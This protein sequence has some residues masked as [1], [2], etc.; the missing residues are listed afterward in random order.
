MASPRKL[1]P[2]TDP[3]KLTL[4]IFGVIAFMY[5]AGEVLKPLILSVLL[6]FGLAPAA[7]Y[8]ER[9]GLPRAAAVVLTGVLTLGTLGS[10]GYV[11]GQQLTA[12]ANRLPD[13]QDNI[14]KKLN[15]VIQPGQQS[16]AERL[17]GFA[18]RLSAK[19]QNP[20]QS[21]QD[22]Q[23]PVQK[24]EVISQPSFQERL[25]ATIGPYLEFLGLGSFVLVLV[26]F[27]LMG[28]DDLGDRIIQLFGHQQVSLT[29][30]TTEEIGRRITRY[31]A[32]FALVN[33]S[34]GLVIG[35]GLALI[36]VPYSVLWGCLAAM[37]RFIPYVGPAMA[38]V[39]PLVFSFAQFPGWAQPLEVI[40][41]FA[42][43]ELVMNS[44][45]EPVIYGKTTGVSALGLLVAAMFWT[46][47]W[48]T[49]GLLLSTPMTVCLAVLGKYVPN[50]RFFATLLGED[51]ELEPDVRFY[52]RLVALDRGG[53]VAL[54][55]E[56]LKQKPRVEVFDEV[57]IPALSRAERDAARDELGE[58]EQAFVWRVVDEII[59]N[60]EGTTE[61]SLAAPHFG[62]DGSSSASGNAM[63]SPPVTLLGIAV[64]DTSD[65]LVLKML[66]QLIGPSGC[67][68]EIITE[69]GS[70][71][72]LAAKVN[73]H[74]PKLVVLSHLPPS[75]LV[76]ARYLVKRLR[77]QFAELPADRGP[78]GRD[79]W[80]D[81]GSR[82]TERSGRDACG[83]HP[84]RRTRRHSVDGS[85]QAGTVDCIAGTYERNRGGMS[86]ASE[87][88]LTTGFGIALVLLIVNG[89]FSA[90]NVRNLVVTSTWV[91]HSRE[92]LGMLDSIVSALRKAEAD[93]RG[94]VITGDEE[95]VGRLDEIDD[96]IDRRFA[97]LRWLTSDNLTQR[98]S[99]D[100]LASATRARRELLRTNLAVRRGRGFDAARKVIASEHGRQ[101]MND[102]DRLADEI[103]ERERELLEQ[104]TAV[105]KS[106]IWSAIGTFTFATLVALGLLAAA[107]YLVRRDVAER[108]RS[109]GAVRRSEARK[110][111]I[112]ESALDAIIT[113]DHDGNVIEFNPAA[114]RTFG[115]AREAVVGREL[116]ELIIPPA[117]SRPAPR[118]AGALR[119]HGERVGIRQTDRATCAASRR[120]R[121]SGRTGDQ[122]NCARRA[123]DVHRLSPRHHRAEARGG[124][125]GRARAVGETWR[126][127][128]YRIDPGRESSG[129]AAVV[130]RGA[131]S[132]SPR[133]IRADLD[134]RGRAGRALAASQRG[135]V[136]AYRR[137]AQSNCGRRVQDRAHRPGASTA[138][139]QYRLE[140]P[141]D[142]R[143]G[144]GPARGDGRVR[145]LSVAG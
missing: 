76:Q 101:V 52:Q 133:C 37:M 24:V 75:G 31:L 9:W 47:L 108:K 97:N 126:G 98:K 39:L 134:A 28:R 53:A 104:R 22:G 55:E 125:D 89:L 27:M 118:R 132:P 78:V 87:R 106:S 143:P 29:T 6:S 84:G 32:T 94:Y 109:D 1:S 48:G 121:I 114:E 51:A 41:L 57:L 2:L 144:M 128:W 7:R 112:L 142:W 123:A 102:V 5:F 62:G 64:Q 73:E 113:I 124:G 91:V 15:R 115:Y 103:K 58:Q 68:L 74:L 107:Y 45:L 127:R 83:L 92:V 12:L 49:V 139:D 54:V 11:V 19:M 18:D 36:G 63:D 105:A 111:A 42:V 145:G 43:M 81:G 77:A 70:P 33:S 8:L 25:K 96:E 56:A 3:F 30:R 46:W 38:F 122:P 131:R 129:N 136:H 67:A 79:R 116:A 93:Q 50:L 88:K 85:P 117:P 23:V 86:D 66:G 130:L 44:F 16:A 61:V 65:V 99:I 35:V 140:R 40:A 4:L 71:L 26:L 17:S 14:E 60:L 110:A 100:R 72:E 34:F 135:D 141:S 119:R 90:W 82:T 80:S 10:V 120:V 13:Y 59:E 69:V 21:D 95:Y 138:S 137:C 20:V